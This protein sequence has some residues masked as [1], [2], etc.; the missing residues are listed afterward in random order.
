MVGKPS[1]ARKLRRIPCNF[2]FFA[3]FGGKR[4]LTSMQL[5]YVCGITSMQ[6]MCVCGLLVQQ[7]CVH[8]PKNGFLRR[9]LNSI[10]EKYVSG[11]AN[12]LYA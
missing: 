9:S 8:F 2:I 11:K 3:T 1:I 12:V 10:L 4:G 5:A 7:G 6:H